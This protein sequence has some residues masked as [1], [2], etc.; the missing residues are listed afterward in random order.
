MSELIA[1]FGDLSDHGGSALQASNNSDKVFINGKKVVM[2][3]STADPDGQDHTVPAVDA[4]TGST[5]VFVQ[6]II[7]H[8]NDDTRYCGAKTIVSNQ[9]KVYAG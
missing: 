4:A 2:K 3:D 6:G 8:R 1:V 9:S 7:V 5:K